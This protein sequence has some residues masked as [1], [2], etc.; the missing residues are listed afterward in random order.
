MFR[1]IIISLLLST[2]LI[3]ANN[4]FIYN[5]FSHKIEVLVIEIYDGDTILIQEENRNT[6]KVRLLG[7]DAP[8]LLQNYGTESKLGLS[9]EI[10]GEKVIILFN[11]RDKFKRILGKIIFKNKDINLLQI[12]NGYSWHYENIFNQQSSEDNM[13]YE[14]A[15]AQAKGKKIGLWGQQNIIPPWEFRQRYIY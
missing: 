2:S 12:E 3:K 1:A 6:H 10:Y 8:E 5:G 7:I 14:K 11:G 9:K 13:V 4:S 15:Q